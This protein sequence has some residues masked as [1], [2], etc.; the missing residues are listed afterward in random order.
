MALQVEAGQMQLTIKMCLWYTVFQPNDWQDPYLLY[1][2]RGIPATALKKATLVDMSP[3]SSTEV[4]GI[5]YSSV[6][7]ARRP[8]SALYP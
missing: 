4:R 2:S 3:Y 1:F 5:P 7:P 8:I 6:V